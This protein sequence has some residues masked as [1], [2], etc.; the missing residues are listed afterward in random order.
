MKKLFTLLTLALLSI[1]TAWADDFTVGLTQAIDEV[2]KKLGTVTMTGNGDLVT[3]SSPERGSEVNAYQE[4]GS[5]KSVYIDNVQYG[6]DTHWRKSVNTSDYSENQWVGYT[7]TIKSGYKLNITGVHGMLA[8]ADD[9]YTWKVSI[10][11]ASGDA[12]YESK[13]KTTKKSSTTNWSVATSE[14]ET[15]IQTALTGLTGQVK[16]RVYMYQGGSTKYFAIPYLTIN[17]NVEEDSRANYTI[18]A[19]A[20]P[21]EGG[22]VTGGGDW[23]EGSNVTLTATPNEGYKFVSWE[24]DG[25]GGITDN[26]YVISDVKANHTAVANFEKLYTV[27]YDLSTYK[28]SVNRVLN[29]Y[30]AVSGINEKYANASNKYTIPTYAHRYLYNEGHVLTGWTDGANTYKTGDEITL[31]GDITLTPVWTATTASLKDSKALS[32]VTWNFRFS[33]ILFNAWQ[34]SGATGYYTKPQTV[35]G[36]LIAVPMIVDATN[37]KVDNSGRAGNDNAQVNAGTK[38]TIPAVSGM[39]I[40]IAEAN[41]EFSTTTI[42]GSTEY[43]GTGTK[44][45]SYTYTGSDETIDIIINESNQYLKT[46]KVTYPV[47]AANVTIAPAKEYTTYIAPANLDFTGLDIKAYVATEATA[48]A[49]TVEEVTT[50]PAGTALI[51]KKGTAASYDV[52]V[53][54]SATAPA[55]N[56]LKGSATA[57]Y[58]I[59]NDGDAYVLSNGVFHPV[60]KGKLNAGKAYILKADVP[61]VPAPELSI[62]F[63]NLTGIQNITTAVK[64]SEGVVFD[65]Q[66]RKVAQPA[67]GLYIVNGK[68][69][70]IK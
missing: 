6:T 35:N 23:V 55:K 66:G 33:E 4:T 1:G 58:N 25:T 70:I 13:N 21:A 62:V 26:P 14:L 24:I 39:K 65:L 29:N 49:I 2:N 3:I 36:E 43:E 60:K 5:S 20:S 68:K 17:G 27:T 46:I 32:V 48:S 47:T 44:S 31:T 10:Q 16:V 45:I 38:F 57:S 22:S 7:L 53:I 51:L 28:G 34:S 41:T 59:E 50:V 9:T 63:G 11:N 61:A 52:P 40:E 54:A 18:T 30:I 37:G 67:K 56:L 69:V 12:L 19:S 8:V 15:E 64:Q 42:A